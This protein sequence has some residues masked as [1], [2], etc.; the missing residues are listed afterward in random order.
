MSDRDK[1]VRRNTSGARPFTPGEAPLGVRPGL[2]GQRRRAG[3][4]AGVRLLERRGADS[5]LVKKSRPD[6]RWRLRPETS[7]LLRR[8]GVVLLFTSALIAPPALAAS[9]R[10]VVDSVRIIGL[11]LLNE[12]AI[13]NLAGISTGESLLG[14][15]LR[16]TERAIEANPFV[17][18]ARARIGIPGELRIE[19]HETPLLLR[20]QRGGE[21]LLVS[22]SG[23]L[24][25][26][27]DSP[28]LS[29][30][31]ATAAA[32]LP[33]VE[34]AT[35]L[36]FVQL[37]EEIS[38]LDLDIVTRLASITPEDLGSSADLLTIQRDPQY[39]YL[40]QGVGE[41]FTWNAVFGIYSA[42]IRPVEMLPAQVR[43]LRSLLA[44]RERGI[45]WVIL[46]DGQAGTFTDP[47]VRPPPP[48]SPS[49]SPSPL[50]P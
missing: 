32:S 7:A 1:R 27:I 48:P 29:V 10:L 12:Q 28:L 42:T 39:G 37:G 18:R 38:A 23:R 33:L 2:G 47:G 35:S 24:L 13:S 49:A 44:S 45:G 22:G 19:I 17:A 16:A 25:G 9:G 30:R 34:D 15:E 46:A 3:A 43:L 5:A 20:W 50:L 41:G 31:G 8:I 40:L 36:P 14:I 11:E 6:R 26:R 4:D 21:T